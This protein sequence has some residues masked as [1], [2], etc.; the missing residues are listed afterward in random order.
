LKIFSTPGLAHDLVA[1]AIQRSFPKSEQDYAV[2]IND[3][4]ENNYK[5]ILV[6]G[7]LPT[8]VKCPY[9]TIASIK[10]RSIIYHDENELVKMISFRTRYFERYDFA[11]EWNN[12]GYGKIT[13]DSTCW[14]VKDP[15]T[16]DFIRLY[17]NEKQSILWINRE[18]GTIDGLDWNLVEKFFEFHRAKELGSLLYKKEIPAAFDALV[19]MRIDCDENIASG[20]KLFD[21]YTSESVPFSLALTT[22][23]DIFENENK[24]FIFDVLDAGGSVLSHSDK[25]LPQWGGSYEAAFLDAKTSREKIKKLIGDAPDYIVSPFHQNP[26]FAMK[27]IEDAGFRG[28]TSGL[29][30]NDPEY[31]LARSGIAP[32]TRNLL[33]FSSQ[34]M[35][36]G[37]SHHLANNSLCVYQES[38]FH[39][40]YS[41]SFFCY[42]DH[43]FSD[44][45]Y[46]WNSEEER[47]NVH[48][49]YIQF[50]KSQGKIK[51]VNLADGMKY[52]GSLL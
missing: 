33:A 14:S 37:D 17:D 9:K 3:W 50:M 16:N 7:N 47:C 24:K 38:F 4:T 46:G 25:H 23:I 34:C 39:H 5:K 45:T 36:H 12:L 40:M 18:V 52:L 31:I 11:D 35:L 30:K 29:I 41:Q 19:S 42:L 15:S 28:V 20:R 8:A 2:F 44:Y 49:E 43:P 10:D 27:A 22:K 6:L 48:R 51:F 21:V 1:S 26:P 32:F 13:T